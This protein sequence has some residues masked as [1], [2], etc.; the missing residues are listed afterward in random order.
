MAL[1]LS[2]KTLLEVV[3]DVLLMAGERPVLSLASTPVARKATSVLTEAVLELALLDDWAFTRQRINAVSWV[4]NK[5]ELG[6]VQRIIG[7]VYDSYPYRYVE[8]ATFSKLGYGSATGGNV[9]Y[10]STDGYN[11]VVV[12]RTPVTDTERLSFAFDVV[13]SLVPPTDALSKFPIPDRLMPM[14]TKRAL[15]LFVLRHLDDASL[16]AQYNNEFEV[17]VQLVRNRERYAPRGAA[18][19]YRGSRR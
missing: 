2:T 19:L 16:A 12:S 6:N 10:W 11:S 17:M 8:P 15:C 9:G 1:P 7:V 13:T 3:N 14:V 18:N 4:G 5:A